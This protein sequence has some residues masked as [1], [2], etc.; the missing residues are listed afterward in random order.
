MSQNKKT[1]KEH[2]TH[3]SAI[4]TSL[5]SA[6]ESTRHLYHRIK[7]D[8]RSSTKKLNK[9]SPSAERAKTSLNHILL[10]LN[11]GM[12]KII[13]TL[14]RKNN[15]VD[16][17][18]MIRELMSLSDR[19]A[20][21][22]LTELEGFRMRLE[23]MSSL[24]LSG[25]GYSSVGQDGAVVQ[26]RRKSSPGFDLQGKSGGQ[27]NRQ[28]GSSTRQ[29]ANTR[30][31]AQGQNAKKT[32]NNATATKTKRSTNPKRVKEPQEIHPV[33]IRSKNS[34]TTTI[35]LRRV[36]KRPKPAED[37]DKPRSRSQP[38]RGATVAVSSIPT[39]HRVPEVQQPVSRIS[40]AET[41]LDR[42]ISMLSH[43]SGSTKL[44]E[45]PQ[46]KWINPWVPPVE[47]DEES[48]EED[49]HEGNGIED[50]G[51]AGIRFWRR[52]GRNRT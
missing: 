45:I 47:V 41:L 3:L 34:S 44:G 16:H 43:S 2:P 15:G 14:L 23:S 6:F 36:N 11:T 18:D 9:R 42:R 32:L 39:Q 35:H 29:L 5:L 30:A 50:N 13:S 37:D 26:G 51:R 27:A 31:A 10:V 40:G 8:T 4:I 46:H 21:D 48:G 17:N 38:P 25:R 20:R 22:S 1:P 49:G 19:S 12:T 33:W 52:F 7:N 24:A 28:K